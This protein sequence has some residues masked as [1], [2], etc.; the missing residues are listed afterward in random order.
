MEP[1]LTDLTLPEEDRQELIGW[2]V[3]CV[4]RLLPVFAAARP[5]DSRL[6]DALDGA[7]QFAAGQLGVGPVRKLAFGCHTSAREASSAPATAVARACGQAV[8]VAHMAGHSR[9]I[10]RYTRKALTGEKLAQELEWQR[11]H[12]PPGSVSTSTTTAPEQRPHQESMG[13]RTRCP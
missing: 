10:A 1:D 11:T 4:E 13:P 5:E 9:E 7:R 6:G 2:A 8:A 3:A 12:V